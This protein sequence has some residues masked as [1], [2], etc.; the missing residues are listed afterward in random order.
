MEDGAGIE[1]G[2]DRLCRPMPYH[3]AT[4]PSRKKRGSP[5]AQEEPRDPGL[6]ERHDRECL[7]RRRK[8]RIHFNSLARPTM[9]AVQKASENETA[10]VHV[11]RK[12]IGPPHTHYVYQLTRQSVKWFLM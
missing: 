3:L 5:K 10:V 11:N 6:P 9:N 2:D 12:I 8:P 4:R 1:P 7:Y